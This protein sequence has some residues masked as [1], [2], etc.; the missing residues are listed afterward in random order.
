MEETQSFVKD[1]KKEKVSTLTKLIKEYPVV[2][3]LNLEEL[4]SSQFQ[5]IKLGLKNEMKIVTSR[6]SFITR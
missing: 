5:T 1:W 4:P 3:L 2:G 6:K